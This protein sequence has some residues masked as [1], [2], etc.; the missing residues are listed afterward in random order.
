MVI[1]HVN[2][3]TALRDLTAFCVVRILMIPSLAMKNLAL[4][5]IRLGI[6]LLNALNAT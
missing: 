1:W 2:A 6:L 5:A 3:P 4:S